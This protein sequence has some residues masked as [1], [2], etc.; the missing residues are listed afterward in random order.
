VVERASQLEK[1]GLTREH[2]QK[3]ALDE[4]VQFVE[5]MNPDPDWVLDIVIA[6]DHSLSFTNSLDGK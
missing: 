3:Q 2:A 5:L 1:R 6:E 4:L